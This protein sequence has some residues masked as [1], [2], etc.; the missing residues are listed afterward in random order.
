MFIASKFHELYPPVISDYIQVT[1]NSYS[2]QELLA[3]ETSVISVLEFN[4]HCTV[5]ATLLESYSIA[6]G[7]Y[8]DSN[9]LV[10]A[11][12]LIDLS[13]LVA[14]FFKFKTSLIVIIALAMGLSITPIKDKSR[15]HDQSERLSSP[16][17]G[18]LS[19]TT[20]EGRQASL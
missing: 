20:R 2:K 16:Q 12:F 13:L 5:P 10:Y 1:K 15:E 11:S 6:V 3:M 7:A 8:Q 9:V 19:A 18:E 4:I 17:L 14:D